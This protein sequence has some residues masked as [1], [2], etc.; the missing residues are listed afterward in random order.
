MYNLI[1]FRR[2]IDAFTKIPADEYAILAQVLGPPI[3]LEKGSELLFRQRRRHKAFLICDGWAYTQRTLANGSRQIVDIAVPGDIVG[4]RCMMLRDTISKGIM[5]SNSTVHEIDAKTFLDLLTEAPRAAAALIWAGSKDETLLVERLASLGRRVAAERVAH[6]FLELKLRLKVIGKCPGDRYS[7][8]LSQG[9][10]ADA[11]GLTPAHLNRTL[12]QLRE[13]GLLD[14][15]DGEVEI[16]DEKKAAQ[17]ALFEGDYL[18]IDRVM[19]PPSASA[20][21]GLRL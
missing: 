16:S 12:R 7:C 10:I 6:F 15:H 14:F 3:V 21:D 4:L 13:L 5:L 17:F 19:M 1:N 2:K 11:L 18:D 9:Q 20:P 8:P